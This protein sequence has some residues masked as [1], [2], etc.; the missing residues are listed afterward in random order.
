VGNYSNKKHVSMINAKL[1]LIKLYI[2]V[3]KL[4]TSFVLNVMYNDLVCIYLGKYK[5]VNNFYALIN[6]FDLHLTALT[7]KIKNYAN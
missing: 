6:N 7:Y 2:N 4:F 5:I 3:F 1:F